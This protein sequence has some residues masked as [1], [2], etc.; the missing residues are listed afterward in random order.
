MLRNPDHSGI[1]ERADMKTERHGDRRSWPARVAS[2][3]ML[4]Y[5]IEFC[6]VSLY[7]IQNF[8]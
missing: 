1:A 6:S 3:H 5:I 7:V 4:W 8:R 2:C